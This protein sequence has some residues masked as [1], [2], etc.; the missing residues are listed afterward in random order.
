MLSLLFHIQWLRLEVVLVYI[1][2]V[3]EESFAK[4]SITK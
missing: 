4:K 3:S 1:G 2:V